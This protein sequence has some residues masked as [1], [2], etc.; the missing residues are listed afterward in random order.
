VLTVP[1]RGDSHGDS[2][3]AQGAAVAGHSGLVL[4]QNDGHFPIFS[5]P[6]AIARYR[7]VPALLGVRPSR[8][9]PEPLTPATATPLPWVFRRG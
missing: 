7:G 9:H 8:N 4:F 5:N 6:D 1:V 3:R 2:G